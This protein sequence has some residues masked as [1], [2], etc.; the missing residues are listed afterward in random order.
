MKKKIERAAKPRALGAGGLR[1]K[2]KILRDVMQSA[3]DCDTWLT[4]LDAKP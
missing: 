4:R 1:T 2:A 3:A